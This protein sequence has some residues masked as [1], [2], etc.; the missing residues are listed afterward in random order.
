MS[1]KWRYERYGYIAPFEHSSL[2]GATFLNTS[3][4]GAS[5]KDADLHDVNFGNT[6]LSRVDLR[7]VQN[8]HTVGYNYACFK[9]H[10]EPILD[11]KQQW[12][13]DALIAQRQYCN[14]DT[15]TV[16]DARYQN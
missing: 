2:R 4:A 16:E 10:E 7:G 11:E 9:E 1:N 13:K 12:F 15:K 5:F 6:N 8:L 3:V 14:S